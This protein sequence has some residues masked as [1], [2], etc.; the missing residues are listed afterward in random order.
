MIL[1]NETRAQVT[2]FLKRRDG[3]ECQYPGC[4]LPFVDEA[5]HNLS[6]TID[7]VYPQARARM[8]GWSMEEINSM[9]NLALM[10]K[11]CNARKKDFI[12]NADGTLPVPVSRIKNIKSER[13][14]ICNL[15]DSGRSLYEG[16]TCPLCGAKPSPHSFPKYLQREPK[17][18]DHAEFH[19]WG[20]VTGILA[21][22]KSVKSMMYNG[23]Q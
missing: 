8:E 17:E 5:D 16:Q 1:T 20:C 9:D 18:C 21:E 7:H 23:E 13:P 2:E 15:C 10:H 12:Y 11:K 19:C 14:M 22:R 3:D 4:S 6:R